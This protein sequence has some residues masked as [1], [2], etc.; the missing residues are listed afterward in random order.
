MT[1]QIEFLKDYA[2]TE[3]LDQRTWQVKYQVAKYPIEK[4]TCFSYPIFDTLDEA[5]NCVRSLR[6]YPKFYASDIH[7]TWKEVKII[8]NGIDPPCI[9]LN[10]E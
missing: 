7:D 5:I 9:V 10:C 4:N 6:K 3:Y 8:E 1:E 2:I